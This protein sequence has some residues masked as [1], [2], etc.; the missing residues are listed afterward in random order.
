AFVECGVW[1]GGSMMLA[2]ET[3]KSLGDVSRSL[4]LY[5]TYEGMSKPTDKDVN[6]K[7]DSWRKGFTFV[8]DQEYAVAERRANSLAVSLEQVKQNFAQT[9]YPMDCVQFIKGKVEDTIPNVIPDQ[10]ALLRL[11][12]DWYESTAHELN[13]LFPRLVE[14]GVLILDDY[15]HWKGAREA[16]D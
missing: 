12:T 3:L 16:V 4:Y 9:G 14:G 15:G 5:D 7:N 10:I 2:A 6:F 11:D 8:E 13:H 1:R